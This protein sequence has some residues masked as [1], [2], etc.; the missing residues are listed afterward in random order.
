MMQEMQ[1]TW[2]FDG[3]TD[4]ASVHKT[5]IKLDVYYDDGEDAAQRVAEVSNRDAFE[6]FDDSEQSIIIISPEQFAGKYTLFVEMRPI[7]TA[8]ME[9]D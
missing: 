1:I 2:K 9:V 8:I 3:E 4:D 5:M 6:M 7:Y